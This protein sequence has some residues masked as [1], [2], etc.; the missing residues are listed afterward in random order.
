LGGRL[1]WFAS[2]ADQEHPKIV[3]VVLLRGNSHRVSGPHAADFAGR[4]YHGLREH[5][6][7]AVNRPATTSVASAAGAGSN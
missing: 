5:N 1:V 6:Y 2:Y 4:I 7:I 3:L